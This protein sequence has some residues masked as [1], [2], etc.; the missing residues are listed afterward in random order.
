M[1]DPQGTSQ[2][3]YEFSR[4]S[5]L[6][7]WWAWALI[8]GALS[9]LL[10][11]C[12]RFYRRDVQEMPTPIRVL[13]IGLR[14]VTVLALVFFFFDLQRRT[15]RMVTRPSEVA[16]LVDT[17][18]SMSLPTGVE[19]ATPSRIERAQKLVGESGLLEK[20]STEHRVSVYAFGDGTEP[21]LID[22]MGGLDPKPK[23]EAE[24]SS[25]SA[26][27]PIAM[28]AATLIAIGVILAL[29]SLA[30]A[31]VGRAAVVGW[32]LLPAAISILL[33]TIFLG[34]VYS[35]HT[36]Q[37]LAEMLGLQ[38]PETRA[39]SEENPEQDTPNQPMRAVDWGDELA[40][41]GSESRIGDAVQNILTDHD[42][43][44]L[45]GIVLISD[46]QNNGGT[47]V[48]VA[49]AAARRSQ[50]SIYPIGL[51]SS[52][53]PT[54]VRIVDIDAPRRV[55]PGDKFAVSAV[56]QG[57]GEKA[58]EVE[59]QLLD[60][61]D[62]GPT[63]K[64]PGDATTT[65]APPGDV[66]DSQKVRIKNDGTLTGIR[67]ELEPEAV[68]RRRLAIRIVSPESDNNKQDD[69]RD[70]RYEVVGE[71]LK[72]LAV[73]GGP[74][75]EYRFVRNL[76]YRDNS[77]QLDAWLQTGQPGISQDAD[78]VLS[79]FPSTAEELFKYD[80]IAFFDPSWLDFSPEQLELLSRWLS[81]QAGGMIIVAGPVYHPEWKRRRTDPR[82]AKIAGFYPLSFSNRPMLFE[83][84]RQGGSV[85]W[86]LKFTPEA[87]RAEFLWIAETPEESEDIWAKFSGVYD[88][89]DSKSA[90]AGAKVYALFAD[91]TTEIGGSL[92][93]YLASQFYGA[94][95]VYFQ[96]SGEMWRLRAESDAYFDTYYTKLVRW[97]SE[98]RLLRDSTRGVLLVDNNKAMI[99]DTIVVRAVLLNEQFEPLDLPEVPAKLLSPTGR[100]TDISLQPLKGEPRAG[101]YGGRFIVR[102]SGSYELRLTLGDALD[103]QVLRQSVQVRLPTVEL[104][105]PRRNDEELEQY[106]TIT[107]G[108]YLPL[109]PTTS[110]TEVQTQLVSAVRPQ[111]QVTILPGTPN[112]Q[113]TERR[114]VVL[115]WLIATM[116][117]MEWVIRRLHRLA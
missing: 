111:P 27:S 102:E 42:P 4:V 32:W 37:S 18:Q 70:A 75:R 46:G 88:Y 92:P 39:T 84:G 2:I 91:P 13:L 54:N 9:S 20:L 90:K 34:S 48:N 95:K 77:I 110:N 116:L 60:G 115:M 96:G 51:G 38:S 103:E 101:T 100:I 113:F 19:P 94:G 67:F 6:E 36:E 57:S 21:R 41:T 68:G 83:G 81:Q 43:S 59:V 26:S 3:I 40:A 50:V 22:S 17:S 28:L 58:L 56:L 8:T 49:M 114:N 85:A 105:R 31:A 25:A 47:D 55:Y 61:L 74:T 107:N 45:A 62:N 23:S 82:M 79:D 5:S 117:T 86:P 98:G 64:N 7:G 72:V 14:L 93:I 35:V 99:G 10:Y 44:T 53:A 106:A 71:K 76:L 108:V 63:K 12:V 80:T 109:D 78:N 33:G 52:S 11:L 112:S 16:V 73:A 104:E 15:E 24:S 89:V 97:V 69:I 87:R 30:M 66:I 65:I 1:N 29:I